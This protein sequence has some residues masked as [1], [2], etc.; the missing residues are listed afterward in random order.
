MELSYGF[1]TFYEAANKVNLR[2]SPIKKE[3]GAQSV[4]QN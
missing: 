1:L 4:E 3:M 2:I